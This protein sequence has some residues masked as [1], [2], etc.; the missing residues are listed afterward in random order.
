MNHFTIWDWAD[1]ARGMAND[2]ATAAMQAHL[3][4]GCSRCERS[5]RVLRGVSAAARGEGQ[6][7]PPDRA[8]RYAKALFSLHRPE[9]VGFARLVG[10]LVH[11]SA[12][13]PLPAGMRADGQAEQATRHLL[14]E[15][16][17]YYLDVQVEHQ[18]ESG[19]V[20]LVGQ[21][22]ARNNTDA[23]TANL[24]VWLL[25]RSSLVASTISNRF[26]EFQLDCA[27]TR[28]LLLRVPLPD[29]GKRLEVSLS[30]PAAGLS[31]R[32]QSSRTRSGGARKA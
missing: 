13:A 32:R 12:F 19:R 27:P 1:F 26:G 11:D 15:A 30:Q 29:L 7:E 10:R 18:P 17:G 20:S 8:M 28:N 22:A 4:S 6:H 31:T 25:D 14:Y 21:I 23:N 16:G 3:S 2:T 9:K 24:P 5:V